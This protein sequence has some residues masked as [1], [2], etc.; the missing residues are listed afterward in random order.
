MSSVNSLD[1][2]IV[3]IREVMAKRFP[4]ATFAALLIDRPGLPDTVIPVSLRSSCE[5]SRPE[6]PASRPSS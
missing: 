1:C 3:A 2:L 6:P 5:P 4:D